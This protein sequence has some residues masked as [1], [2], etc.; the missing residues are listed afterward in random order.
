MRALLPLASLLAIASTALAQGSIETDPRF[1]RGRALFD[2]AFHRASGLGSPNYNGDSCRACHQDPRLGGAGALEL[3]VSRFGR[4]FNGAGPF[5]DILGGQ[6]SSKFRLP[7]VGGREEYPGA[8]TLPDVFE[9][10]QPPALFGVGLIETISGATITANEDPTDANQDGIYGA[11]RR[12][13]IDGAIEIG[14]YGWKAQIPLVRDFV[15]DAMS[16]ELGVTTPGEARPF[17]IRVD[18]DA[19]ADP[20]L[21]SDA[22]TDLDFFLRGL[23]APSRRGSTDTRVAIGEGVFTSVGCA[24]CHKPQL[25]GS[26]GPV[27]LYSNLLLHN[28]MPAGF[29]GM[30]EPGA[31]VGLYRTPP[32]WGVRDTA[33]YLHDG[34]A[35]TLEQAILL[36]AGEAQGVRDAFAARSAADQQALLLFLQDL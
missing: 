34:R 6:A 12:I 7:Q 8:P 4:D 21:P 14:R 22:I 31:G 5:V 3:N 1:V 24:I 28:V 25:Q 27:P 2:K 32:L 16:E 11:A 13:V 9:Q 18:D 33:P 29:R 19:I 10:R 35:E 23:A 15:H 20:E 26:E 30:A 17:G 36:H